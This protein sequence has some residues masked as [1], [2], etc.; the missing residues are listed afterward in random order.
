[1]AEDP[2]LEFIPPRNWF[3]GTAIERI[4]PGDLVCYDDTGRGI[5]R[6]TP[7]DV[8]KGPIGDVA[9]T[10]NGCLPGEVA[11]GYWDETT[12]LRKKVV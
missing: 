3:E 9:A 6:A 5:R 11:R 10:I 12:P 2:K 4:F 7:A 1:M 8:A